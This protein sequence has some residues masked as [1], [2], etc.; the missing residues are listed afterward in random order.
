MNS[1]HGISSWQ[2]SLGSSRILSKPLAVLLQC[3]QTLRRI[4]RLFGRVLCPYDPLRFLFSISRILL[5]VLS[6]I[7]AIFISRSQRGSPAHLKGR[8][9]CHDPRRILEDLL[10]ALSQVSTIFQCAY[11][12]EP[13]NTPTNNATSRNF[14][15]LTIQLVSKGYILSNF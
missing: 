7:L 3:N 14:M 10:H 4:L 9:W 2:I 15:H 8:F 6:C 12:I 13:T 11:L 5:T 1:F